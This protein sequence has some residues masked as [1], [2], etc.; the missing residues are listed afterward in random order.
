MDLQTDK[1]RSVHRVDHVGADHAVD[2][3]HDVIADALD[4]VFVPLVVF[5]CFGGGGVFFDLVYPA[6][7][8][9][10]I[11][12]P[13]GRGGLACCD[14]RLVAEDM[15]VFGVTSDLN[16][17]VEGDVTFHLE[18]ED[19]IALITFGAEES[20]WAALYCCA[21]D[22][23]VFDV[24]LCCPSANMPAVESFTVKERLPLC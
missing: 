24:V 20:V 18:F 23:V 3:G 11:P 7:T 5:E 21:H 1:A 9:C 15:V 13:P 16:A 10:F 12:Y 19:E 4:A 8:T 6:A 17:G 22:S 14:F 2:P